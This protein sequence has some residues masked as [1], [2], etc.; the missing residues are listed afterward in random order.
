MVFGDL[1]S[2]EEKLVRVKTGQSIAEYGKEIWR[3]HNYKEDVPNND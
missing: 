1:H 3:P 2:D